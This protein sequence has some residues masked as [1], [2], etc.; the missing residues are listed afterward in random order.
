[1]KLGKLKSIWIIIKIKF[2]E[3]EIAYDQWIINKLR[4]DWNKWLGVL[5]LYL[6]FNEIP[7]AYVIFAIS[8]RL[9]ET[10]MLICLR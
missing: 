2:L 5:L 9:L 3:M 4:R 6:F 7:F 1:M 10:D 8:R